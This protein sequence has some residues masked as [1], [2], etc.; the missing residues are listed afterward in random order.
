LGPELKE[1]LNK[2][3]AKAFIDQAEYDSLV[4]LTPSE[5]RRPRR[6]RRDR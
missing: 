5:R 3:L 6:R 4:K 2:A 1:H